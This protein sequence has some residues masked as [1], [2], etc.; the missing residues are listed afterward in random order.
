MGST[1]EHQIERCIAEL[2]QGTLTEKGLRRIVEVADEARA[3]QDLLYLHASTSSL[4]SEVLA[5]R[6][7]ENG[8]IS[9]GP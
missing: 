3:V 1:I 7:V 8:E 9:D 2:K 5:M 4:I 6:I